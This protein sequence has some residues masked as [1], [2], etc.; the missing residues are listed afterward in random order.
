MSAS[1]P[2]RSMSISAM[3][4]WRG[5]LSRRVWRGANAG[6]MRARRGPRR[7]LPNQHPPRR[8][9]TGEPS[10]L[11]SRVSASFP[12]RSMSISSMSTW[13]GTPSRR[14][15]RG[16]SA[17]SMRARRGPRRGLP[18]QH[19]PRRFGTGEPSCLSS[20]VSASFPARSMSISS[21]STWPRYAFAARS[22]W[23]GCGA[24]CQI[25]TRLGVSELESHRA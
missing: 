8:F 18:N 10:C 25:N 5:M 17:C 16:P 4:M 1:S 7:G 9:G 3:S 12:A 23:A 11:S 6:S 2:A 20:R 15:W 13:P 14:V 21:M 22:L 24:G 19:A